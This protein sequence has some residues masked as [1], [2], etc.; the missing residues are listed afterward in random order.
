MTGQRLAAERRT[1]V[2][3]R[4]GLAVQQLLSNLKMLLCQQIVQVV[5]IV[6]VV[7]ILLLLLLIELLLLGEVL[8]GGQVLA[9]CVVLLL[10]LQLL[11]V[12][13]DR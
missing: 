2:T 3:V 9:Q 12:R 13:L 4:C 5:E 1:S 6:E 8:N 7:L 11:I 10:K